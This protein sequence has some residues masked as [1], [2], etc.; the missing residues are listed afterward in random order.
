[1]IA[2]ALVIVALLI[3]IVYSAKI[4]YRY[5][6]Y[7]IAI[8]NNNAQLDMIALKDVK[9]KTG[10]LLMFRYDCS[11]CSNREYINMIITTNPWPS[12]YSHVGIVIFIDDVP[13]IAHKTFC[14]QLDV[15][16]NCK[17]NKSGLYPLYKYIKEYNGNVYHLDILKSCDISMVQIDEYNKRPFVVDSITVFDYLMS[18][19]ILNRQNKTMS[20]SGYVYNTL[21]DLG[22]LKTINGNHTTPAGLYNDIVKTKLYSNPKIIINDYIIKKI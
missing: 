17:V 3:L 16:H 21:S 4:A 18:T 8:V 13:Y 1:M 19:D 11:N 20:C 6:L 22:I 2:I 10:D 15:N 14:E 5:Q 7:D 9:F 12:V